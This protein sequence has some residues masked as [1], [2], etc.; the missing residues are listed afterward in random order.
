MEQ[1]DRDKFIG[2]YLSLR[3]RQ[4]D[5]DYVMWQFFTQ[6][7]AALR[8]YQ[9]KQLGGSQGRVSKSLLIEEVAQTNLSVK[10]NMQSFT[11]DFVLFRGAYIKTFQDGSVPYKILH[12]IIEALGDS[13]EPL[14]AKVHQF[15]SEGKSLPMLRAFYWYVDVNFI[16]QLPTE[17][18]VAFTVDC[19]LYGEWRIDHPNLVGLNL[20]AL[21]WMLGEPQ[22]H[23]FLPDGMKDCQPVKRP[24]FKQLL[25][26]V[27]IRV[28]YNDNA[29]K[30]GQQLKGQDSQQK[31][32]K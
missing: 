13:A 4:D 29:T 14:K 8:D 11:D 16:S 12:L 17:F 19:L 7:L 24:I 22:F 31:N 28:R 3:E 25:P 6:L 2:F 26:L 10:I 15:E 32:G 27:G 9:Q 30:S 23:R 21:A 18:Q 5:L 20:L 1:Q